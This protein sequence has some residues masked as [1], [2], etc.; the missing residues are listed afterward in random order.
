MPSQ[1]FLERKQRVDT[2]TAIAI[3][4]RS[5][6]RWA[7]ETEEGFSL[8]EN[9]AWDGVQ[10]C[11]GLPAGISA[12]CNPQRAL[13]A[14]LAFL[15]VVLAATGKQAPGASDRPSSGGLNP[16]NPSGNGRRESS[17]KAPFGGDWRRSSL[18]RRAVQL[19][20][21][22][23]QNDPVHSLSGNGE[24]IFA[25]SCAECHGLDGR[26]GERA[27]NIAENPR[28]QRLSDDQIFGVIENGIP[29]TGMPAFHTLE[30]ADIRSV[31]AYL[32]TLQ[33]RKK[34]AEL[35]GDPDRGKAI[36]FGKGKC[37]SCH[38]VAGKGGF[39][40][41]DLSGYA[42]AHSVEQTRSAITIPNPTG[43]R[44]SR[45]VTATTRDGKKSVGRIRNE[46][47]FSLQLQALDGTF[48]FLA[49]PDIER[50]DFSPQP[51]MPSDFRSILGPNELN[52]LISYLI[53]SAT[54]GESA[55]A[56]EILEEEK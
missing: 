33:G 53:T 38:M 27:P 26:G 50:L 40:A 1:F 47:N 25:G 36:F 11:R 16:G 2:P 51:L 14:I 56:E 9:A 35:P 8:D 49:K 30:S 55:I 24:K 4:P 28:V 42:R 31:V 34:T 6:L 7:F 23:R 3:N 44:Q 5:S 15:C 52:D 19:G 39:I 18:L 41:S 10:S 12:M 37:S 29:G 17:N 54:P 13:V 45:T 20:Q 22:Q 43:D 46:D 21:P 32:R 48:H